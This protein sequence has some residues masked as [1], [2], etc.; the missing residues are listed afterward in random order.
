MNKAL[1]HPDNEL[2]I[3]KTKSFR[4]FDEHARKQRERSKNYPT[5]A[6]SQQI[7]YEALKLEMAGQ[8]FD[9]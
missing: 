8:T 2:P 4:I 7:K 3:P 5:F 6:A 9:S 1:A